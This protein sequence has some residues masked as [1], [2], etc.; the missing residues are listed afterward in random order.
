MM[1]GHFIDEATETIQQ[2][3]VPRG[4]TPFPVSRCAGSSET[5]SMNLA[6]QGDE[7]LLHR[8]KFKNIH[9]YLPHVAG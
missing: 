3:E 4:S 2:A 7:M 9:C 6:W 8:H 5:T 1:E